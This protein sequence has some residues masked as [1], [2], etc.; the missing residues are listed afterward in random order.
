MVV[1]SKHGSL[2]DYDLTDKKILYALSQN[3]RLNQKQLAGD[4]RVSPETLNY[5]I[6]RLK[7]EVF[8][9]ALAVDLTAL[10][11]QTYVLFIEN[12]SMSQYQ[13]L[14]THPSTHTVARVI[15]DY[16]CFAVITTTDLDEFLAET[17]SEVSL[18]TYS[19]ND[20]QIDDYNPWG[21]GMETERAPATQSTSLTETHY[22]I[23]YGS[24]KHPDSS[25]YEL[26]KHIDYD[27]RT[28]K[29]YQKHLHENGIIKKWRYQIDV[30]S[31]GFQIYFLHVEAPPSQISSMKEQQYQD[32]Y[33]GL[34]Y[35]SHTD[36]F[37]WYMPSTSKEVHGFTQKLHKKH[38][39]VKTNVYE[40]G[41]EYAIEITPKTLKEEIREHG[42][43]S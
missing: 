41:S 27:Y 25:A 12:T 23:L 5:R 9:P 2:D 30:F 8:E 40:V 38:S 37:F 18:K 29:K 16:E 7:G 21:I 35:Q 19:V 1:N 28:I 24:M 36:L 39:S 31:L 3:C 26:S 32:N 22:D 11:T 42:S 4:L 13:N 20:M 6:N 15:G 14:K 33:S 17:V 43:Q 10:P 34:L